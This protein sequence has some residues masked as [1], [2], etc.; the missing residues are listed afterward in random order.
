[1]CSKVNLIGL[2]LIYLN[3]GGCMRA[4]HISYIV[5]VLT[6]CCT[7]A[8]SS[9]PTGI[10]GVTLKSGGAGCGN[11]CHSGSSINGLVTISGPTKLKVGQSGTYTLTIGSG[12]LIGCDIAASSGTLAKVTAELQ[13]LNGELTHS[14]KL[15]GTSVQ[16]TWTPAAVGAETLYA[17]GA[18]TSKNS[19]WGHAANL[20]VSVG[21]SGLSGIRQ[22]GSPSAFIL[23]QNFP[24]PFNPSTTIKFSLPSSA[25]VSLSIMNLLGEKVATLVAG[26]L[27]Q[28]MHSIRWDAS[29][30]PSGVYFYQLQAVL[31]STGQSLV[32]TRRL[33]LLR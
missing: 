10:T 26:R 6:L 22:E 13:P 3:Q 28:G 5:A 29:G 23:D 16:F 18:K 7:I 8:A 2:T 4:R 9:F 33:L 24:N 15:T 1:M 32:Q 11:G 19:G 12:T 25:D 21:P 14:Q 17:T 31:E 30:F 27:D 20:V